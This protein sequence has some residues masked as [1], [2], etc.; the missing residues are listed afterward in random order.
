MPPRRWLPFFTLPQR[1][2][3]ARR[4]RHCRFDAAAFLMLPLRH[5]CRPPPPRF[6]AAIV[7]AADGAV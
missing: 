3:R 6:H 7:A 4:I 2:R 1:L 5:G